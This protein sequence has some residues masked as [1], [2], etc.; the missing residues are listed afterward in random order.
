MARKIHPLEAYRTE[1]K[2]TQDQLAEK[3]TVDR[4]TISKIESGSTVNPSWRN[5]FLISSALRMRPEKLFPIE[6]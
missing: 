5:V 1:H 3:S 4:R 6:K 2:M